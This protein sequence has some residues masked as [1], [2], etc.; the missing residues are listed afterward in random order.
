MRSRIP[1]YKPILKPFLRSVSLGGVMPHLAGYW[2]SRAGN[3]AKG[4]T[5][6]D[7]SGNGNHGVCKNN[8]HWVR[9]EGGI[10]RLATSDYLNITTLNNYGSSLNQAKTVWAGWLKTSTYDTQMNIIGTLNS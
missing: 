4:G 7:S 10:F 1:T 6:L 9:G 8:C 2:T 3:V 5:V